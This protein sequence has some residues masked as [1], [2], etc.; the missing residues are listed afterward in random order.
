MK[1]SKARGC[2]PSRA[3]PPHHTP[4]K[5]KPK[6]KPKPKPCSTDR[7]QVQ[8]RAGQRL[9]HRRRLD[10]G[11]DVGQRH[12]RRCRRGA[13]RRGTLGGAFDRLRQAAGG[14]AQQ[15]AEREADGATGGLHQRAHA[16]PQ[17]AWR[18]RV[19][20]GTCDLQAQSG[21]RRHSRAQEGTACAFLPLRGRV[22]RCTATAT[23][24]APPPQRTD[25]AGDRHRAQV[26]RAQRQRQ[27][28][29]RIVP[30]RQRAA[31][32]ARRAARRR[33]QRQ[34]LGA[35]E[36]GRGGGR[37]G[38]RPTQGFGCPSTWSTTMCSPSTTRTRPGAHL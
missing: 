24:A 37:R 31:A 14:A 17:L 7:F 22:S 12:E 28:A 29:Q 21:P 2:F 33:Q 25:V 8:L 15:A 20:R 16:A 5:T 34:Q 11:A 32:G 27:R 1:R 23:A 36:V 18:K 35:W 19:G 30:R 6:R 38:E 3:D 10:G 9:G 4:P 13:R 26:A